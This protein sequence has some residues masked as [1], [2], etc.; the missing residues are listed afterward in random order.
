MP[1]L[2]QHSIEVILANQAPGGAFVACPT[3]PD[4]QYSWFRDGS[5]I[6]YALDL[7]GEHAAAHRF[8]EWAAGVIVVHRAAVTRAEACIAEGRPLDDAAILHTRY[9]IEGTV[10]A[11]WWPNF[12]LDGIGTWLWAVGDHARRWAATHGARDPRED[13]P[14]GWRE[15]IETAARYLAALWRV[16]NYDLWEENGNQR[17]AYT[18]AAVW[19]GLAAAAGLLDRP[20]L[21]DAANA[22]RAELLD[23]TDQI[24]HFTKFLPG[25][26]S[27]PDSAPSG[28]VDGSLIGVALPHG[29]VPVGHPAFACTGALIERGLRAEGGGVHRFAGDEYYG[30]GEWILL[31]AWLGWYYAATGQRERAAELLAW[32]EAQADARGNL[33]EQAPQHLIHP[34]TYQPW[35][36][37][38]GP[39]AQPLL[40]SHAM[41]LLLCHAL[42]ETS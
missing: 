39:I 17:H 24:G 31:T 12:Q 42:E 4:Y 10:G 20:D 22:V 32:I 23:V 37:Q 25:S 1:A 21:L 33:A 15:A 8:H 34:E 38:R 19:G 16:P 2:R 6:A 18:Q 11:D 5:Y 28:G 14:A 41:Y 9:T 35:V 7:V 40:W 29:A 36:G 27:A 3:M 30:G 26:D 13:L